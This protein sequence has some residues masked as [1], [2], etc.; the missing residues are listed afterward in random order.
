MSWGVI[1]FA[2]IIAS[3]AGFLWGYERHIFGYGKNDPERF[4]KLAF[5]TALFVSILAWPIYEAYDYIR[6]LQQGQRHPSLLIWVGLPIAVLIPW[7]IGE[8][9]GWFMQSR[10]QSVRHGRI[11]TGFDFVMKPVHEKNPPLLQIQL[12]S[13]NGQSLVV[14]GHPLHTSTTPDPRDVYIEP[15]F[16]YGTKEKF[17]QTYD[18]GMK[19][20]DPLDIGVLIDLDDVLSTQVLRMPEPENKSEDQKETSHEE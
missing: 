11:P 5:T 13:D 1:V 14:L 19:L 10:S 18:S 17:D 12:K 15:V 9:W 8:L 16:F 6:P 20:D 2:L 7:S 4:I 3:G